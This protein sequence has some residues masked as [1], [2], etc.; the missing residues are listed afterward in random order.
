ML[1]CHRDAF[2]KYN[3]FCVAPSLRLPQPND[4]AHYVSA[5]RRATLDK[6][7]F[8]NVTRSVAEVNG[9]SN[10]F[11]TLWFSCSLSAAE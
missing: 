9:T 6:P 7:L 2:L 1:V 4:K 5:F 3:T 11:C 10:L 8:V